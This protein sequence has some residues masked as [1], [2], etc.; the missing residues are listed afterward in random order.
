MFICS[1]KSSFS[2][3]FDKKIKAM[4]EFSNNDKVSEICLGLTN[5]SRA[6]VANSSKVIQLRLDL[7]NHCIKSDNK[8][9]SKL[10]F[11]LLLCLAEL[12]PRNHECPIN[13]VNIDVNNRIYV[14]SGHMHDINTLVSYINFKNGF[15]NPMSVNKLFSQH[16]IMHI[17]DAAKE[18][19]KVITAA[20]P[21]DLVDSLEEDNN[22]S[23]TSYLYGVGLS[24]FTW[25]RLPVNTLPRQQVSNSDN[26]GHGDNEVQ[27]D[28]N[29]YFNN[30]IEALQVMERNEDDYY[31]TE[32][33]N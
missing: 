10:A 4:L 20:I 9:L 24:F 30:P 16:D 3:L 18:S 6:A 19:N 8:K 1:E 27:R 32:A 13:Y 11:E 31:F 12:Q 23:I 28:A 21:N 22:F 26:I 15:I 33:L 25:Q 17:I 7:Q 29:F 5:V 14:S 2:Q